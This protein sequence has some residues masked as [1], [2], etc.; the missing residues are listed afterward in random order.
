MGSQHPQDRY[1]SYPEDAVKKNSRLYNALNQWMGQGDWVHLTHLTACVS[2][3]VALV[4]TGSVNLTKWTVYMPCR[5]QYAASK[6][7]RIQRWLHNPRI[8]VHQL[9]GSLIQAALANWQEQV[10]Y[11]A[12]D[13]SLFWDKYCLVRLCVVHRGRA[14]PVAWRVMAHGSASVSFRDYREMIQSA[15][16]R[17]P[18]D[19]KVVL[20][21]D[22]GFVHINLMQ[23]LTTQL[24]WH[25]RIRLKRDSWIWRGGKGWCQLK[26]F[27]VL[28][29]EALCL[30]QVRLQKSANYGLVHVIIGRNNLKVEFWAVV[31]DE[32]TCLQTFALVWVTLRY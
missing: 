4:H 21:A 18:Q 19:I 1:H 10:I 16:G 7:R 23:M 24:G 13:T 22:R 28:R 11:L 27:H 25:Y 30:H 29:G 14:L 8:N 32:K 12:L 6:Q 31:S 17:L 5:G 26:D 20:L 2:M 15:Q 9:Y 3:L